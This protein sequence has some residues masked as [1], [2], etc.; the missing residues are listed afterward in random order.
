MRS[1]DQYPLVQVAEKVRQYYLDHNY[2]L[3]RLN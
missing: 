1:Q 2:F 3:V